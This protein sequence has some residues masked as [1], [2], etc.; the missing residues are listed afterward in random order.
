MANQKLIQKSKQSA[1]KCFHKNNNNRFF[2]VRRSHQKWLGRKGR[3][4]RE[5]L[6]YNLLPN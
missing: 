2:A 3:V 6:N 5:F 1:S 4:K